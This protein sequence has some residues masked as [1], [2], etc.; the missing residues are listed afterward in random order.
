MLHG[1]NDLDTESWSLNLNITKMLNA[2]YTSHNLELGK[3]MATYILSRQK[4]ETKFAYM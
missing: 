2:K 3:T 4:N 1:G